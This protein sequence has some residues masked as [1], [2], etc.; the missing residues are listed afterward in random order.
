MFACLGRKA[1]H[2]ILLSRD[3]LPMASRL[4][5]FYQKMTQKGY[6]QQGYSQ[7]GYSQ[8]GCFLI[9]ILYPTCTTHVPYIFC[10]PWCCACSRAASFVLVRVEI[11][12]PSRWCL[13][14]YSH[15]CL[16]AEMWNSSSA[17]IL[18]GMRTVQEGPHGKTS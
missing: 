12:R 7:K 5:R 6:S 4:F 10:A 8:K 13:G 1:I 15:A 11:A 9:A 3:R 17:I 14:V 16:T 2:Q 18:P